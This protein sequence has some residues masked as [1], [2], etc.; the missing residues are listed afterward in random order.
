MQICKI[1]QANLELPWALLLEADPEREVVEQYI[2]QSTIFVAKDAEKIVGILAI[3]KLNSVGICEYEL[4]NVSVDPLFQR[5]GIATKLI[6]Y[7]SNWTMEKTKNQVDKV[8]LYVK[9]GD[10]SPALQL[11]KN[12]GFVVESIQKNYFLEHYSEPI[13]ELGQQLKHQ[14]LLKKVLH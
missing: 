6:E 4:M 13:Y 1:N 11:Y 3:M 14:V 7:A 5:R 2:D 10:I 12:N 8:I 9:T